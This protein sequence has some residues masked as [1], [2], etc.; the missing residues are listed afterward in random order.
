[1]LNDRGKPK[2]AQV[3]TVRKR[4]K[5]NLI[6][7]TSDL[8]EGDSKQELKTDLMITKITKN[9][10]EL[11]PSNNGQPN[12]TQTDN[13]N[14]SSNNNKLSFQEFLNSKTCRLKKQRKFFVQSSSSSSQ[15]SHQSIGFSEGNS[16]AGVDKE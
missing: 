6:P 10:S 4:R 2:E 9:S 16:V 7:T 14:N 15:S 3:K 12:K 8:I 5:S 1:M 13:N 11:R